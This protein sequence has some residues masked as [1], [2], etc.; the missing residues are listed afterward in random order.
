MKHRLF[1]IVVALVFLGG[2]LLIP[3]HAEEQFVAVVITGNL[4]RYQQAHEAF[5]KIL[6]AGG[7]TD[8]RVKVYVQ[9]PNPD[10]MSWMNSIRKAVGIGADLIVTYG[11][12]VTL[13]AKREVRG[14]PLL[15]A[16]VYD[17]VALGIVRDLDAPGG[18]VS[19]VSGKTPMDTLI[20]TYLDV[21]SVK[22]MGVLYSSDEQG[23]A[24]QVAKLEELA[25]KFGFA[26]EKA[27]LSRRE[28]VQ[29]AL[30]QLASRVDS[31][32]LTESIHL[33]QQLPSVLNEC[34]ALKLPVLSQIPGLS[35]LGAFMT[36]EADPSEQGQMVGVHALQILSGVKAF[37]LPVRRP[38]KVSLVINLKVAQQLDLKVPFQALSMATRVIK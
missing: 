29:P 35:D 31:L 30:A 22:T 2:G 13:V 1:Q 28:D 14:T 34:T 3:V 24:L 21:R 27:N 16:D 20:K 10:P 26:L 9:T 11:A 6:R 23:S 33:T 38:K 25:E 7:A 17:P 12:P 4:E 18:D 36:L 5:V 15:F 37:S 19:G 32:F 8:D